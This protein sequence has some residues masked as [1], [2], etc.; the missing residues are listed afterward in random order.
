MQRTS[1]YRRSNPS[2][3]RRKSTSE[4]GGGQNGFKIDAEKLI[5]QTIFTSIAIACV[6]LS[7]F[8]NSEATERFGGNVRA[9]MDRT[10]TM[11]ELRESRYSIN[12]TYISIRDSIFLALNN[13]S[14]LQTENQ[15]ASQEASQEDAY[16]G[17]A[18]QLR[19]DRI[20][21]DALNRIRNDSEGYAEKK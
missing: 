21:M 1:P 19:N 11:E 15:E 8:V 7:S 2:E 3:Y 16:E 20:D 5:T 17:A 6:L 13:N 18:E 14:F 4:K 12:A 9:I 10:V